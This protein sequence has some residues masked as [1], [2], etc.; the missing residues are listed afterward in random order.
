MINGSARCQQSKSITE[1]V[2]M[3]TE[4]K[5]SWHASVLAGTLSLQILLLDSD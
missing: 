5:A 1:R 3:D 4:R 2:M